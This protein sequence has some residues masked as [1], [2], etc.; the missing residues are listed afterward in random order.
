MRRS[1]IWS[2]AELLIF[3]L[4]LAPPVP[5]DETE[6]GD[7]VLGG[8]DGHDVFAR[9]FDFVARLGGNKLAGHAPAVEPGERSEDVFDVLDG[10]FGDVD[11]RRFHL[12]H[13]PAGHVD[14]QRGDVVEMAMGDEPGVRCP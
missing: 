13:P 9:E 5:D 10:V 4:E 2:P 14:R 11:R 6:R 3:G 1:R 7:A 12:H 8:R